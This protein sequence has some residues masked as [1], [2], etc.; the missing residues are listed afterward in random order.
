MP[1]GRIVGPTLMLGRDPR[2]PGRLDAPAPVCPVLELRANAPAPATGEAAVVVAPLAVPAR[3]MGL[4]TAADGEGEIAAVVAAMP[5]GGAG[6]TGDDTGRPPGELAPHTARADAGGRPRSGA[7]LVARPGP[8]S[9]APAPAAA[10]VTLEVRPARPI[11]IP[12]TTPL[13]VE[14]VELAA[15]DCEDWDGCAANA[16]CVVGMALP[17]ELVGDVRSTLVMLAV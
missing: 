6:D 5:P 14:A 3:T 15:V 4:V 12:T 1:M 13:P 10:R 7:P 11:P 16:A 17:V 9:P 8:G 2:R